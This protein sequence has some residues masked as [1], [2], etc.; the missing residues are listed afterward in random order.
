MVSISYSE[1]QR[2]ST[3]DSPQCTQNWE[4]TKMDP[5]K[6]LKFRSQSGTLGF[7]VATKGVTLDCN[8]TVPLV[9]STRCQLETSHGSNVIGNGRFAG[10]RLVAGKA[11]LTNLYSAPRKFYETRPY[12]E[13]IGLKDTRH[14]AGLNLLSASCDISNKCRYEDQ[15]WWEPID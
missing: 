11:R 14:Y 13:T 4:W 8:N 3:S 7:C 2:S 6:S 12:A 9:I 5:D 15:S 10:G 1:I